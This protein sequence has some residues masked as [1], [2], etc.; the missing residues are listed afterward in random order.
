[1]DLLFFTVFFVVI[2]VVLIFAGNLLI[3]P[4]Q[5]T[6]FQTSSINQQGEI[7]RGYK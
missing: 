4:Y 7:F 3:S 6:K 2:V 5:L 1:M